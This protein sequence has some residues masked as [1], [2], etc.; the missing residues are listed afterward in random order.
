MS[1]SDFYIYGRNAVVEALSSGTGLQKIYIMFGTQGEAIKKIFSNAKKQKVPCIYFDKKKFTELEK[2]VCSS[3]N[4]SQG[5]IALIEPF[6]I[7]DVPQAIRKAYEQSDKPI[8]VMLDSINDPHNL[9]AIARSCE[10]AGVAGLILSGR[11]SA[12][13]T[14]ASVKVSAGA[15][16]HLTIA[17]AGNLIQSLD[18]LKSNGFWIV[19]TDDNAD[20]LYTENIYDSPVVIIV[21]S[22]GKGMGPSLKKHCDFLVKI[23]LA[24]KVSSLNASVATGVILFEIL[25]QRTKP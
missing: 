2:T 9:G 19:G 16:E 23:P 15:M 6:T 13:I 18:I 8:L 14:P 21:G 7:V 24:G 11:N 5:V 12:P 3:G 25:R 10:C 20:R 22:E 4:R 17:S 1:Q